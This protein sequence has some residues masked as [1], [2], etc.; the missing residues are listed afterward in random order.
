MAVRRSDGHAVQIGGNF[1]PLP[2][3]PGVSY[4]QVHSM[5]GRSLYR[6][7]PQTTYISYAPGC[8]GTRPTTQ[9]IPRDTPKLGKTLEVTLLDL[10]ENAA[11][12]VFGFRSTTPSPLDTY[13]MP[14]CSSHVS[15]DGAYL[16]LG[17]NHKAKYR[18]P[19]PDSP[20]LLGLRFYNQAVVLDSA[21]NGLGAVVSNAAEAVIGKP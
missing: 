1:K 16:L 7:G 3:D 12:M 6:L 18:L 14:G 21:A 10:P 4:V 2:P 11:F 13:G 15:M 8:S 5:D 17:Q 19:I 9:L 20:G